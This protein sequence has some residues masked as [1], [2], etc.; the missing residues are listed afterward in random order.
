[1]FIHC[2]ILLE[3]KKEDGNND[4]MKS[5]P[6][7]V[8]Y[9]LLLKSY[10]AITNKSLSFFDVNKDVKREFAPRF[11]VSVRSA[12]KPNS[13]LVRA[14]LYPLERMVDTYNCNSKKYQV[15]NNITQIDSFT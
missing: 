3:D 5:I 12:C 1:M 2:D 11:I 7:V 9:Q 4:N 13:Y 10:S 6:L 15:C 8:T 14:K